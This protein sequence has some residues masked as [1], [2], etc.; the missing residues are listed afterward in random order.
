MTPSG[1][2]LIVYGQ[3][4]GNSFTIDNTN[5]YYNLS[6]FNQITHGGNK[7]NTKIYIFYKDKKYVVKTT[8]RN[9]RYIVVNKKQKVCI[10]NKKVANMQ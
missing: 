6:D 8:A 7:Q 2:N 4:I 10:I 9:A 1:K 3:G 5:Y